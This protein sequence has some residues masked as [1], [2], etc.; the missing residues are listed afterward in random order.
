M[1]DIIYISP[2]LQ[3]ETVMTSTGYMYVRYDGNIYQIDT[4]DII[5][6]IIKPRMHETNE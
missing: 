5:E 4:E 6:H 2:G 3:G 1:N